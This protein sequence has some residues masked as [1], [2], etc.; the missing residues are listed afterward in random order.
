[1]GGSDEEPPEELDPRAP[2]WTELELL[3]VVLGGVGSEDERG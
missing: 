1:M 2:P 3:V